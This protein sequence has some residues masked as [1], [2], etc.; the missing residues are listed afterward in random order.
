MSEES[1]KRRSVPLYL[2]LG[3]VAVILAWVIAVTQAVPFGIPHQWTWHPQVLAP[4]PMTG[5]AAAA[6]M[7]A[8]V[9]AAAVIALAMVRPRLSGLQV[10]ASLLALVAA[11]LCLCLGLASMEPPAIDA[12]RLLDGDDP[13]HRPARERLAVNLGVILFSDVAFGYYTEAARIDDVG[14]FMRDHH[15]R[16]RSPAT[17]QRVQT[18]PAGTV[19]LVWLLREGVY[20]GGLWRLPSEL[21]GPAHWD[22]VSGI[23]RGAGY[24]AV[25]ERECVVAFVVA[26]VLILCG[27]CLCIPTYLLAVQMGNRHRAL[28]TAAIAAFLPSALLFVPG[29]DQL[30][31]LLGVC[32]L[33][34]LCLGLHRRRLGLVAAAGLL[35]ALDSLI[36]IGA[37]SLVVLAVGIA[38][39]PVVLVWR[40]EPAHREAIRR[41]AVAIGALLAGLLVP[42]AL[43]WPVCGYNAFDVALTAA[44]RQRAIVID[45]WQRSYAP[46]LML[47]LVDFAV[48]LGPCVAVCAL[49]WCVARVRRWR[50]AG[51]LLRSDFLLVALLVTVALVDLSGSARAEV[52]RIW[53][54]FMP[55]VCILAAR[56]ATHHEHARASLFAFIVVVMQILHTVILQENVDV[57][58]PR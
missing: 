9:V 41:A 44:A 24:G 7:A 11:S 18:H 42:L 25:S 28:M 26:L 57:M 4:L 56:R 8:M 5:E 58:T 33:W 23:L 37:A 10:A 19:L 31:A 50:A 14:A 12:A 40:Q 53:M 51:A 32:A 46:W 27:S 38:V 29:I 15:E 35:L 49:S 52:G 43:L 45:Q 13:W 21:I 17:P 22:R 3:C 36:S 20:A 48:F 16:I 47:N 6:F 54:L 39:A 34:L 55:Y 30:V 1:N 2:T